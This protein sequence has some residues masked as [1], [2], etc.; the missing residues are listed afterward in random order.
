MKTTETIP[1]EKSSKSGYG[2][3][4]PLTPEQHQEFAR[5]GGRTKSELRAE[6]SRRNGARPVRP[7]QRPRGNPSG[8]AKKAQLPVDKPSKLG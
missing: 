2:V 4:M 1:C 6:T 3:R 5:M 7:G 8:I